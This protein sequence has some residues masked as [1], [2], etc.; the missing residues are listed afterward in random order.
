MGSNIILRK[1]TFNNQQ[2]I[3]KELNE[4][5]IDYNTYT[6]IILGENRNNQIKALVK[7]I[8]LFLKLVSL[9]LKI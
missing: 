3:N 7:R 5:H 4:E 8:S 2:S 9:L 1:E 6:E